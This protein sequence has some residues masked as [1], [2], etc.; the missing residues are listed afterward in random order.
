MKQGKLLERSLLQALKRAAKAFPCVLLTGPR[1][2]GKSTLLQHFLPDRVHYISLDDYATASAAK[3]DPAL[4]LETLGTPACIDE[5]QH[6]PELLRAIKA[7]VDADR[8][9][10]TYFLTGSQSFPLMKGVTESLSGRIG[11]LELGTLSQRELAGAGAKVP[12]YT[13]EKPLDVMKGAS[14]CSMEELYMRIWNGGYPGLLCNRNM[15]R[16]LFFRSYLQTYIERDV[17]ALSQVGDKGA[18][19]DMLHALATL[20]GQQLVYSEL[21]RAAGVSMPTAKRWVSILETGGI[22][23]L[24]RPYSTKT[25]K[26]L[27]KSPVVHFMDT[28]FCAWLAGIK[29]AREL[30]TDRRLSG[31]ILESWVYG[32]LVRRY[33]N[34]GDTALFHFYRDANG[35]EIDLLIERAGTLYPIEV[36]RSLNPSAADLKSMLRIPLGD[37]TLAP[38]VVFCPIQA[39][40]PLGSGNLA[41]P[42]SAI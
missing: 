4:F 11:V 40:L 36:K 22:I 39:P 9:P 8:R 5:I 21:A 7:R 28:G 23:S 17:S 13:P 38:G 18:F 37:K 31:H 15:P 29:S 1:Q 26:R 6:A 19:Q 20:T 42:I 32:Q 12:A 2:V 14:V 10:G 27:T 30:S 33:A 24:L 16:D 3:A 34:A 35:A 25:S 41:L